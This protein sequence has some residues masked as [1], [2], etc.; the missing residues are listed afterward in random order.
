MTPHSHTIHHVGP[1]HYLAAD[2]RFS[3]F[4]RDFVVKD[5][6]FIKDS[7]RHKRL[8]PHCTLPSGGDQLA[9]KFPI[10]LVSHPVQLS[11]DSFEL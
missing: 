10:S 6:V 8:S 1:T 3:G 11:I 7:L 4:I 9:E 2:G 5:T